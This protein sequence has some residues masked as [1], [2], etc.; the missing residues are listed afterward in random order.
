VAST[1]SVNAGRHH[2]IHAQFAVV[3]QHPVRT[4][5]AAPIVDVFA[6]SNHVQSFRFISLRHPVCLVDAVSHTLLEIRTIDH[7]ALHLD[8]QAGRVY[9]L[10]TSMNM[11]ARRRN[12]KVILHF[13]L[14]VDHI[15]GAVRI[16]AKRMVNRNVGVPV[17][18]RRHI[19]ECP[20]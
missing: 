18:S 5:K 1:R 16:Y 17:G 4:V 7:V 10:V 12:G 9:W 19:E 6:R 11:T 15:D 13:G 14:I 8:R 3:S 20:V 2:S